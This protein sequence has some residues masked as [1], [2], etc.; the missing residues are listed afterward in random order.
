MLDN[1]KKNYVLDESQLLLKGAQLKNTDWAMGIC[2]YTGI[3]T[4]IMLNS[5]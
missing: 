5:Q 4:K 2:I 3:E 1:N